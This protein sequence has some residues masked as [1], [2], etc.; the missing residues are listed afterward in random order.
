MSWTSV[1]SIAA[2]IA[3]GLTSVPP[4]IA[5]ARSSDLFSPVDRRPASLDSPATESDGASVVRRRFVKIDFKRLQRA[6][7]AASA[8]TRPRVQAQT[9]SARRGESSVEPAT[10]EILTL[11]LFGDVVARGIVEWTAP[12]FSGGWSISGRLVGEPLGMHT[13]VVKGERIDGTVRMLEGTYRIQSVAGG[14]YA[15]SEVEEP[16]LNCVEQKPD[17]RDR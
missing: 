13:I 9:A 17:F 3:L 16:S 2:V 10:D 14:L 6:R 15:I 8:R 12:T 7:E 11:N 4:P 5:E 1:R